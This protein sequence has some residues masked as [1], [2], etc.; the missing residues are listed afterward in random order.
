MDNTSVPAEEDSASPGQG[1]L[2]GDRYRLESKLGQG[3]MGIVWSGTDELLR[4]P[5]A[6]KEVHLPPG[7]PEDEA[8]EIRE[9]ALREARAIAMVTHPNVVTLYDVAREAGEPFVVMELVPSQSLAA[10]LSE[11]GALDDTQLA[12][13]ADGV[14][15]GLEAAHRNGIIHRDVKPGN[16]L[17]GDDGRIKLSDF[18]ISRNIAETTITRTGIMLGTPSFVAPEIASGDPVTAAAD[19]WELGATLFAAS[20]GGPPYDSGDDPLATI[21]AVV[22]GPVPVPGRIGPIGEVIRGLM[23]K[24]PA[25]RMPLTEVRRRVQHLLPEAGSRPFDMLLDPEALTVRV[26]RPAQAPLPGTSLPR[27]RDDERPLT[28]EPAPLAADPGPLPFMPQEPP[29]PPRRPRRRVL[30]VLALGL[31]ALVLFSAALAGGF[32]GSRALAGQPPLPRVIGS[33]GPTPPAEDLVPRTASAEHTSAEGKGTFRLL[34]PRTFTTFHDE[35]D[36]LAHSMTVSF[37]SPDGHTEVAVQR[38]GNFFR[39]GHSTADYF[40]SRTTFLTGLG[41]YQQL[42]RK[43][44]GEPDPYSMETDVVQQYVTTEH[45]LMRRAQPP[46]RRHTAEQLMPRGG[47]LWVLRVTVPQ[48][49]DERARSLFDKIARSFTP[50]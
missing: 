42:S 33:H 36:D 43:K 16:V 35:R 27:T 23:V 31:A 19:L 1:R 39:E 34:V 21:T 3:A 12:L 22:R 26:R 15:A 7:M 29:P 4:R 9:R 37:V 18:G 13:I 6:V 10:I 48:Q 38:Y 5:V 2:I 17:I 8:N 24:D 28:A 41:E 30:P 44:V 32:I 45:G 40:D 25:R 47:D 11:H 49:E 46:A 50:L 14:A 20:E